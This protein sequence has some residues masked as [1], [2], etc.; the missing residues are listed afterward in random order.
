MFFPGPMRASHGILAPFGTRH[1]LPLT[2][3]SSD[4]INK[5]LVTPV[6]FMLLLYQWVCLVKPVIIVAHRFTASETD[7]YFFLS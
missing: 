3:R 2:E 1:E 5:W 7:D 6:I 4:P